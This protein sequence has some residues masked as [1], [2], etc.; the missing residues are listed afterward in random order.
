VPFLL[1]KEKI[2]TTNHTKGTKEGKKDVFREM[3]SGF[4][5]SIKNA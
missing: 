2:L 5:E 3:G 4:L 1:I